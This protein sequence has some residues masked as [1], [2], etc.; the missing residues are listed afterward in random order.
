MTRFE[1]PLKSS[2]QILRITVSKLHD[3]SFRLQYHFDI[4]SSLLSQKDRSFVFKAMRLEMRCKWR[5]GCGLIAQHPV[6]P[7]Q[8]LI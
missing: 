1:K 8:I 5:I 6:T 7:V 4:N 2:I 3:L